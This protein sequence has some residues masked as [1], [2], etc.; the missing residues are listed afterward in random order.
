MSF[1]VSGEVVW[2]LRSI[3]LTLAND[4]V[5]GLNEHIHS[6]ECYE[7]QIICGFDNQDDEDNHIHSQLC[8]GKKLVCLLSE[9]IHDAECYQ[10][11]DIINKYNKDTEVVEL[12]SVKVSDG[13]AENE[14]T[15]KTESISMYQSTN[16]KSQ[17]VSALS[18]DPQP[19]VF[20]IDMGNGVNKEIQNSGSQRY[21]MLLGGSFKLVFYDDKNTGA[22][23]Y[24]TSNIVSIENTSSS[25]ANGIRKVTADI[26]AKKT[27]NTSVMINEYVLN[28]SIV[29]RN[30]DI[31]YVSSSNRDSIFYGND[32]SNRL[33]V[34]KSDVINLII[35]DTQ[36]TNEFF[37]DPDNSG[38]VNISNKQ[39]VLD[40][41]RIVTATI[42]PTREGNA[43]IAFR[44]KKLHIKIIDRLPGVIY[45]VNGDT[46]TIQS[47]NSPE[48]KTVLSQGDKI[49]LC[50]YENLSIQSN[51]YFTDTS[52]VAGSGYQVNTIQ[53]QNTEDMSFYSGNVRKITA[54]VTG[55]QNGN[56]QISFGNIKYYVSV[57]AKSYELGKIFIID[58]KGN[59]T[60]AQ[61]SYDNPYVM[62]KGETF[63][64]CYYENNQQNSG[65][66]DWFSY[67]AD[68][69]S[70]GN[71]QPV[72]MDYNNQEQYVSEN[73]RKVTA[74]FTA[75]KTGRCT[76]YYKNSNFYVDIRS[77]Y[78]K[79]NVIYVN[80]D[81]GEREK[82]KVHDYMSSVSVN[83]SET[84]GKYIF[85]TANN[86]YLLYTGESVELCIYMDKELSDRYFYTN[87]TDS[88]LVSSDADKENILDT[89]SGLRR[90]SSLYTA[91]KP[92]DS[93]ISIQTN[94]GIMSF[95][96]TVREK[97]TG[98]TGQ[99]CDH[100]DIEIS[101]GGRY[102]I[103][104]TIVYS[105]GTSIIT[106]TTYDSYIT[107]VNLC[108]LFTIDNT[109]VM[110][111][112]STDY[113]MNGVPGEPQYELTSKYSSQNRPE[114][115]Y[116]PGLVNYAKFNVKMLLKPD[117]STVIK[118]V[119]GQVIDTKV[120]DITDDTGNSDLTIPS[121]VFKLNIRSKI[122][123]LNR[124]P[125]HSGLDFSLVA[126]VND[127]IDVSPAIAEIKADKILTGGSLT[128][129]QFSFS[130]IDKDGK[131]VNVAYNDSNGKIV[132]EHYFF[133]PGTYNYTITENIPQSPDN[134]NYDTSVKQIT[135]IV[136]ENTV[137]GQNVLVPEVR[138][139]TDMSFKNTVLSFTN[140]NTNLTV[141]KTWSDGNEKHSGDIISFKIF[142]RKNNEPEQLIS[143]G[144]ISDFKLS[145]STGWSKTFEDLP[146]SDGGIQYSY[147]IEE[148]YFEG[149][150]PDYDPVIIDINNISADTLMRINN[151]PKQTTSI[152]IRKDWTDSGGNPLTV[153][154]P[155]NSVNAVLK[156]DF[157]NIR[158][159]VLIEI[160]SS[161]NTQKLVK[162]FTEYV[163]TRTD[164]SFTVHNDMSK[165][166]VSSVKINDTIDGEYNNNLITVRNIVYG[167]VVKV[168]CDRQY[169]QSLDGQ[170][171][172]RQ[173]FTGSREGWSARNAEIAD[174]YSTFYTTTGN[175]GS[176][177]LK[178]Y[179]RTEQSDGALLDVRSVFVPGMKYSVSA[180]VL[181][182]NI[183]TDSSNNTRQLEDHSTKLIIAFQYTSKTDGRLCYLPMAS[184][185]SSAYT[186]TFLINTEFTVPDDASDP[187]LVIETEENISGMF[188]DI[189]LDEVTVA[190]GGTDVYVNQ[191]GT[192]YIRNASDYQYSKVN[193]TIPYDVMQSAE[194][195]TLDTMD[196][197]KEVELRA[198]E[199]WTATLNAGELN[200][201]MDR[202]YRYYVSEKNEV[203]GFEKI[204]PTDR[205]SSNTVYN[206][207]IIQNR[208]IQLI[209]P[210]TGGP[211]T[212][213]YFATGTTIIVLSIIS[214]ISIL[215]VI[216]KRRDSG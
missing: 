135:V 101:E 208:Q 164:F 160:Y 66:K 111:Y 53:L 157:K 90:S 33:N 143:I 6:E 50:I 56:A 11:E 62:S 43:T 10:T 51:N 5:C 165:V 97:N 154:P 78:V 176:Q 169:N 116:D 199:G 197:W 153:P 98:N 102:E 136:T 52:N 151:S 26:V 167:D 19:G 131:T 8:Y 72:L 84:D 147:R 188:S 161:T 206:P 69:G 77:D 148:D 149:Y 87:E 204:D 120:T 47:Q 192:V 138:Y 4:T 91:V 20:Y 214:P 213:K 183:F 92:G 100:A 139:N 2:K 76:V 95:Y 31:I 186:W 37:Y 129:E 104:K 1:L 3:V 68:E 145:A 32:L 46:E 180:H 184:Q 103:S 9:H 133:E 215:L 40:S 108:E 96:V 130:L 172:I 174:A 209:L 27:G 94:N 141:T 57:G 45:L 65:N 88:P 163:Y 42:T 187:Y 198:S 168:Y 156:R 29:D 119:N 36:N 127:V 107:G 25:T 35:Y 185:Y 7:Q 16:V 67:S 126:S 113:Q 24:D 152:S 60:P 182:N 38:N 22:N 189:Y 205:I 203:D 193:E 54:G 137:N 75:L 177:A 194:N 80:T 159:P 59:E 124:C 81:L 191:S 196:T 158:I 210:E 125:D 79:K 109:L 171:Y 115:K 21:E 202:I 18:D 112:V 207:L 175:G 195:W 140:T 114:K 73:V 166:S 179:N 142:R 74:K 170:F 155:V 86:R 63:T 132:F 105:D 55:I 200:E 34:L 23:F 162:Q 110:T 117:T 64:L 121:V 13:Y 71:T 190:S 150:S 30:S 82:D 49:T 39:S 211:G 134:Y 15:Q 173:S 41:K 85:N 178:I 61:N 83:Q 122:D 123:A 212:K 48:N 181:W 17:D 144:G 118:M 201:R 14:S 106:K 28:I 99:F 128:N 44:D 89:Q 93:T 70:D 12:E 58:T 146:I 216:K